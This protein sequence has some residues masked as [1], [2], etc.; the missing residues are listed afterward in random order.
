M[1][2]WRN[3]L[4]L[5]WPLAVAATAAALV[6]AHLFPTKIAGLAALQFATGYAIFVAAFAVPARA[7][8]ASARLPDYSYG[9]YIY[10]CPAQQV[11]IALGIGVTPLA[12]IVWGLALTL[13]FAAASWHLIESPA[14][15]LKPH[16]V[17]RRLSQVSG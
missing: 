13:P 7:K 6:V 5:S 14:L 10:A 1:Y 4:R 11:A 16:L 3:E 17:R 15:G 8:V 9:I 2:Q 12:N